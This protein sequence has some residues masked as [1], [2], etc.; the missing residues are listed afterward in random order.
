MYIYNVTVNIDESVHLEWLAWIKKHISQVLATGRFIS[1]KIVQVLIKEE[2]GGIT[3]SIQY[4]A[5]TRKDLDAY[6]KK[7]ATKLRNDGVEKF[8]NKMMA[9]RTELKVIEEFFPKTA[10]N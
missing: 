5:K 7:D 2:L 1:A 10:K 6:Y 3:Y 9:F 8:A 4:T